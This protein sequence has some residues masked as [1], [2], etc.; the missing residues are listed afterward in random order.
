MALSPEA[1]V[2][3]P[4]EAVAMTTSPSP[5]VRKRKRVEQQ[6]PA[7]APEPPAAVPEPPAA[8]RGRAHVISKAAIRRL[9]HDAGG[10]LHKDAYGEALERLRAYVGRLVELAVS[11]MDFSKRKSLALQHVFYAAEAHGGVPTELRS[12]V[13]EDLKRLQKCSPK[14]EA[15]MRKK[16]LRHAEISE[17]SFSK[18]AKDAARACRP[19]LR[20]TTAA[21][22]TLQL[23]AE[24]HVMRSFD[25]HGQV[26]APPAILN[27]TERTLRDIYACSQAEAKDLAGVM[28][29]VCERVPELLLMSS[30]KTV[31]DRLLR[32]ALAPRAAWAASWEPPKDYVEPR[33]VK[34]TDRMLRGRVADKRVT[35]GGSL[36]M[37]C[38]LQRTAHGL[39]PPPRAVAAAEATEAAEAEAMAAAAEAAVTVAAAA[40][41]A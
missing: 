30:A 1:V 29:D 24:Y 32:A 9:A 40:A 8:P 14:C 26:D 36:F 27:A 21:R 15:A 37:A 39:E 31:D 12:L 22:R 2:D 34:L 10:R 19:G 17:A 3:V 33:V 16:D 7:S 5:P 25:R 20:V 35:N 28:D 4:L 6:P 18:E 13:A 38:A 41:A 23:L 11:A